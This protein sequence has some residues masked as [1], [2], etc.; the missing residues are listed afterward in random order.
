VAYILGRFGVVRRRGRGRPRDSRRGRR[1]YVT[2]TLR[3]GREFRVMLRK[4]SGIQ[5]QTC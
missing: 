3:V 1:R 5:D 4:T 2:G